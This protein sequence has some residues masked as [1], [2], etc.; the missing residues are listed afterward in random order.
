MSAL[1]N[2]TVGSTVFFFLYFSAFVFLLLCDLQIHWEVSALC[3]RDF[4]GF[5]QRKT[6]LQWQIVFLNLSG[7]SFLFGGLPR[8]PECILPVLHFVRA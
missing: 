2:V 5:V 3:R 8:A 1:T 7:V 4:F 6:K